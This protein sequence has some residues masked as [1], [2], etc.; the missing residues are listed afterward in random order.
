MIVGI[1]TLHSFA[2]GIGM[3]VSFGGGAEAGAYISSA[4]LLHNIPE[5]LAIALVLVPM[6]ISLRKATF[7]SIVSSIP[8]PLIALPAFL[9]VD[10]FRPFLPFGLGLAA[11]AMIWMALSELI[12]ESLEELSGSSVGSIITLAITAMLIFQYIITLII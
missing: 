6:G 12:P 3:G 8:Q 11:G 1:M 10:V 9:F 4:I 2:E 5:G 7:W